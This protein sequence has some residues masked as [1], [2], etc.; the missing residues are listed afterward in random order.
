[1]WMRGAGGGGLKAEGV[2]DGLEAG[3]GGVGTRVA[4][5]AGTGVGGV[6]GRGE[7]GEPGELTRGELGYS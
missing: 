7:M 4:S 3:P 6:A 1:M 5:G 2:Q